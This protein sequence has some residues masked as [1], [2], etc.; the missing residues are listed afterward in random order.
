MQVW[1]AGNPIEI[2]K[3]DNLENNMNRE[4]IIKAVNSIFIDRF[5]LEESEL[6]PEKTI[7][8]DL[9]LDSL[10]IVDM[11]VGLQQKFGINLRENKEI[12]AVRTLED[13]YDLFEKLIQEHP[14]I[15]EK[16]K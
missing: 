6:T 14:E 1:S 15:A 5:E 16:L 3:S 8:D 12:R 7:A 9:Q 10:D 11:I 2:K 13:V 4:E